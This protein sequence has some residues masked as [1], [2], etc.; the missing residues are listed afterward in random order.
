MMS[1]LLQRLKTVPFGVKCLLGL[2][3]GTLAAWLVPD[4]AEDWSIIGT[5]FIRASQLVTMP[6]IMLELACSLGGLSS[7]SLRT[8]L[9]TGGVVF[10]L[11]VI[12]A[13]IAVIIVPTWLPPLTSSNFFNPSLLDD[14]PQ[15]NLIEKLIP[16]NIFAAMAEDNFPAV[17]LFSAFAGLV[18]QGIKGNE[19]LL[20]PMNSARELF[21]KLN[22]VVLKITPLAVFSL[23]SS[24]LASADT[25]ELIRLHAL[26]IIGLSGALLLAVTVVGL[27]MSFSTLTWKELWSITKTPL[28]LTASTSNLI[29]S[30]PTLVGSLQEVLSEKFKDRNEDILTTA[31]EQIGAA[32]PVGFALPTLGQ[33]YMLMMVPFMGW[34]ADRSFSIIQKLHMLA[35]GIPGSIGGI[36]S[37]V[38]QELAAASLPENLLNIFFLNT[39]W[40]Y[41]TEKTLSLIGLIV[42][43]ICIVGTTTGTLRLNSKRLFAVLTASLSLGTVLSF[44]IY[45]M[46]T[47]TLSGSYNK[48]QILMNRKPLVQISTPIASIKRINSLREASLAAF[49]SLPVNLDSIRSRGSIRIGVKTS[50]YPWSFRGSNGAL[51]GYD[52]D[53]IQ[54][55]AN[56]STLNVHVVEAPL[57]VLERMVSNRQLDI[58]LGGIEENAYRAIRI[59]TSN[60]YQTIHKALIAWHESVLSVQSAESNRLDRPLRIAIAD[61]YMPSTDQKDAIEEYLGS[62]GPPVPVTFVRIPAVE[63]FY[64]KGP[65]RSFDALLW[66]AEGGSSWSVMYPKTDVLTVF[67]SE[68]PNQMVMLLAGD[69]VT[70]HQY[71]NE[72]ISIQSSEKLFDKLYRHWIL[73]NE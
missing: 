66:S 29:I 69:D 59:H 46:L 47:S 55:I 62:P 6:F 63:N 43:V 13:S 37:V 27:T 56:F 70:W 51:V 17:V 44:G 42:L 28:I 14:P 23:V 61:S 31:N 72:W 20:L 8:L 25:D 71:I 73:V 30:L 7:A 52:V 36:R 65:S 32:V 9:R 34:Y 49:P 21:R 57:E 39:E 64:T 68:L 12:L 18:L 40:I 54:T 22:K 15:V 67:G 19:V 41:R 16:F 60:G 48:D 11:L 45:A 26:P 1:D 53:I 3:L 50:D 58:A 4:Y 10:V 38:R 2:I 5:I 33:V 35:T 24:T